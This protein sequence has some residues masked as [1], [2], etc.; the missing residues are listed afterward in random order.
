MSGLVKGGPQAFGQLGPGFGGQKTPDHENAVAIGDMQMRVRGGGGFQFDPDESGRQ[1]SGLVFLAPLLMPE[2]E[3]VRINAHIGYLLL[4]PEAEFEGEPD[5]QHVQSE[6]PDNRPGADDGIEHAAGKAE[7]TDHHHDN[8]KGAPAERSVRAQ[9]FIK[10]DGLGRLTHNC[11]YKPYGHEHEATLR[12]A[13]R[14]LQD[15]HDHKAKAQIA[16]EDAP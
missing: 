12:R 2:P 10:I 5:R 1:I 3:T 8:K 13:Y 4:R 7:Q 9:G 16:K 14:A 11:Q 15:G 6:K